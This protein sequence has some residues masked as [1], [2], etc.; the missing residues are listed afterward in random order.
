MPPVEFRLGDVVRLRKPH[1]CGNEDFE[2]VRLG[3]DIGL[4]C[5]RCGRRILLARSTLEPRIMQ[6]VSRRPE[7]E[8]PADIDPVARP[9]STSP[10][11]DQT[12]GP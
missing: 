2:V 5:T 9:T 3:A 8:L 11:P 12:S 7:S 10:P 6:F 1:P 4:N